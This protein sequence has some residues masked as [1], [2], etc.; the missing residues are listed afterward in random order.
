MNGL[1]LLGLFLILYGVFVIFLTITKKPQSIWNMAK[2]QAF[3]KVLGN[4]GTAIFF[5]IF[6][7]AALGIGIWL[8]VR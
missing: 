4:T 2:V 8:L 7:A 6:G 3:I 5:Y 1:A